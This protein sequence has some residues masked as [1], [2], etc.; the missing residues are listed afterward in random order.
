L[1]SG[2]STTLLPPAV[3]GAPCTNL[4][5]YTNGGVIPVEASGQGVTY[6]FNLSWKP[7]PGLLMYGTVSRGF[8]PGGINRRADVSPYA[9]DF[10][11]NYEVGAKTTWLGG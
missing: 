7:R 4:G 5:V 10:L 6:R 9:A 1:A 3:A 11:T 8:R 2:G